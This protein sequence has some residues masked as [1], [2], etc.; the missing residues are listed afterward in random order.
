[1]AAEN[2]PIPQ[3]PV[4]QSFVPVAWAPLPPPPPLPSPQKELRRDLRDV[5]LVLLAVYITMNVAAVLVTA[6]L[7]I[8][9]P[10]FLDML[11]RMMADGP[12]NAQDLMEGVGVEQ[13]TSD[14]LARSMG[15][16]QILSMAVALPWVLLLRGKKLFTHD[17]VAVN[18]KARPSSI[19]KV[20]VLML[21]VAC[22]TELIA[23]ALTPLLDQSGVS[24]TDSMDDA[25]SLLLSDPWGLVAVMVL[26]P[27]MEE[28]I[29]RGAILNTL[30]RHGY[31]FAIVTSALLFGLYHVILVQGFNAFF[32]GIL[33]AYVAL[34]YS[35]KWSMVLH[36]LYNSIVVGLSFLD[37]TGV[38]PFIANWAFM[39]LCLAASVF[40]LVLKRAE[41]PRIR[42][43]GVAQA[44]YSQVA[45]PFQ[46]AFT[47]PFL[48][49][50][51]LL[52][53]AMGA[54]LL[55]MPDLLGAY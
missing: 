17:L 5:V 8:L 29:F 43:M 10:E 23:L 54:L 3:Q 2:L 48:L 19:F 24:L 31:N 45:R 51:V 20:L 42:Q 7:L 53:L 4:P 41:I 38:D 33:L 1:M 13:L 25:V 52:F 49:L 26:G 16:V 30:A 50:F 6:M 9:S 44:A 34:R 21:G 47:S 27:I 46:A 55:M 39:G 15:L 36:V 22:A 32:L 18:Q 28:V 11:A 14:F 37:V 35:L 40:L 12:A